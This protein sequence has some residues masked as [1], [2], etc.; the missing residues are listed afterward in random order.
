VLIDD[1]ALPDAARELVRANH[2][3]RRLNQRYQYVEG[4][5]DEPLEAD[6]K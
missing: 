5:A 2:R 1:P 3:S 4:A 6:R